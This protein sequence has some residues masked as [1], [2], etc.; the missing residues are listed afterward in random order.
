MCQRAISDSKSFS[1]LC[2]PKLWRHNDKSLETREKKG[3]SYGMKQQKSRKDP[4]R[5]MLSPLQMMRPGIPAKREIKFATNSKKLLI[6]LL[7]FDQL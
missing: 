2:G 1:A 4:T 6:T 5:M 7:L 3:K